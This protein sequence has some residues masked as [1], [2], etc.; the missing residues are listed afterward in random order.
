MPLPAASWTEIA[1][2]PRLV[3]TEP[4]GG[5]AML[6]SSTAGRVPID[7][8]VTLEVIRIFVVGRGAAA[9]S[10]LAVPVESVMYCLSWS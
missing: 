5:E 7:G 2:A 9:P 3:E 4:F 8:H 10:Q 1:S 6:L